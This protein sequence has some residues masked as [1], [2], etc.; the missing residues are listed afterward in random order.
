M[1]L[2]DITLND[3]FAARA[4]VQGHVWHTP[5]ERSAW[6]SAAAGTEVYLKLECFQRTGSFKVRGAF[7][8]VASLPES[9]RARGLITR[10]KWTYPA[11]GLKCSGTTTFA[12]KPPPGQIAGL[13]FRELRKHPQGLRRVSVS[14]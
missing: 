13:M 5:L 10:R 4:R 2:L 3:V 8:A 1:A 11:Q 7:N 14:P 9:E 6:L 12:P